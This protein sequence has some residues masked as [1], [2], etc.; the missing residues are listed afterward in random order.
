LSYNVIGNAVKYPAYVQVAG[1][2]KSDWVWNSTTSDSRGLQTPD[3]LSREAGCWYS[4]SNFLIDLA[5]TDGATHRVAL[6]LCDWD[7][8][9]RTETVEFLNGDT[10]AILQTLN[11]SAFSGG[12]YLVWDFNGHVKIRF[13]KVAGP[14]AVVNGIFFS[15]PAKQL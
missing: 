6:Y 7:Y 13:T 2:G 9:G 3:G 11:I 5:I 15:A 10:G 12:Q 8:A 14:N 1:V 4:P